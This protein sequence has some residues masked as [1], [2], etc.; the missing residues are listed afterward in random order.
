MNKTVEKLKE[1]FLALLPPTIFFFVA[2]HIIGL[3]RLLTTK[4]TG[5]PVTSSAQIALAALIIGKGVLLA[6][7][8]PAIN[9]FPQKPLIYNIAWKTV[10]YFAV[11]S[12]IHYLERLYDFVLGYSG[13]DIKPSI[14][15]GHYTPDTTAQPF[16]SLLAYK[17]RPLNGIWATAPYLHNGSVPTLYDLLLPASKDQ[18][19]ADGESRPVTFKVGQREF[20]P[21]RVG[22][23][24]DKG[25]VF[26]TRLPGNTNVGHEYGAVPSTL[27]DGTRLRAFNREERLD[28]LEYLKSL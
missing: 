26:D 28:L 10:I 2:L 1:E 22:L 19:G 23:K 18:A 3:V 15:Q 25:D 11:A 8:W 27:P 16:N 24:T 6:D 12:F 14:K 20:D 9:R 4:G 7:L 17:A 13:N 5:L 21:Q